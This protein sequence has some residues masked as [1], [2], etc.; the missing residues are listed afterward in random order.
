MKGDLQWYRE[1]NNTMYI[2]LNIEETTEKLKL[3]FRETTKWLDY[4]ILSLGK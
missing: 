2:G 1:N 4:R 3:N